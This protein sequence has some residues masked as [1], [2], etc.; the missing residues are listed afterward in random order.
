MSV[1][2]TSS[3]IQLANQ[4][5][6]VDVG[7]QYI[8]RG[9]AHSSEALFDSCDVRMKSLVIAVRALPSH[10]AKFPFLVWRP[11]AYWPVTFD[12]AAAVLFGE[13]GS[14]FAMKMVSTGFGMAESFVCPWLAAVPA[15]THNRPFSPY[16]KNA[17]ASVGV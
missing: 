4:L 10:M 2:V 1:W 7:Y 14:T 15:F 3:E 5:A 17:R 6:V 16:M 8:L 9:F 12:C 11:T 13:L